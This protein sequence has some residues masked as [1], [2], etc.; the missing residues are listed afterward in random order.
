MGRRRWM[1]IVAFVIHGTKFCIIGK[2]AKFFAEENSIGK[3]GTKRFIY[4]EENVAYFCLIYLRSPNSPSPF[5]I[6]Y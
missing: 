3:N 1:E 2:P 4:N 6:S 5:Q